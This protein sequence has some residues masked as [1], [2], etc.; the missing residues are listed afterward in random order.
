MVLV[1]LFSL[2][3]GTY[4][5]RQLLRLRDASNRIAQE[6]PGVRIPQRGN[7]E[8][9]QAI[10]AFNLMSSRLAITYADLNDALGAAQR[11][12][13]RIRSSEAQKAALLDAALDAIVTIDID[14]RVV[15][16][17]ASAEQIFGH[18]REEARGQRLEQLMIPERYRAA[19][20]R[21]MERFRAEGVGPALGQRLEMSA[22]HKAGREFPI[23]IAITEIEADETVYFT[24]FMRDIS[25][26][27]RT[28][29][30]LRLAAQAF[31]AQEAIC[32]TDAESRILRVNRAFTAITGYAA[33]EAVG[34]TPRLLKSGRQSRRF[35]QE[36]WERLLRDGHW[37]GEIENRR[38]DGEIFPEW[39]SISA[40]RDQHGKTTNYVAHFIDISERK[41]SEAALIEARA[42]AEQASEAKSRF[43]ATMSHEIRTPLNAIL[44]MNELLLDSGLDPEQAAHARVA[45]EAGRALL[46]VV[47]SILDFSK[48][49]AGRMETRPEPCALEPLLEG[50]LGLFAA[51]AFAKGVELVLT[52]DPQLPQ[53]LDLDPGQ[54]RQILLNLL[55]NALKF[56]EHGA[57]ELRAE[58]LGGGPD[59]RLLIEVVD[60]GIG[61]ARE[62]LPE[63]FNEFVQVDDS[64]QRRYGGT[65]LG[66][67]ICRGLARIMGGE[68]GC[69]SEP[70][71][72][73]HFW[74]RLPL[75]PRLPADDR[76]QRLAQLAAGWRVRVWGASAPLA[77]GLVRQLRLLGVEAAV[78]VDGEASWLEAA[79]AVP[80][81]LQLLPASGHEAPAHEIPLYRDPVDA[82]AAGA[83]PGAATL[84]LMPRALCRLLATAL[85]A[86][87]AFADETLS[88]APGAAV[89]A[90]SPTSAAAPILLVEDSEA[91]RQVALAILVRAGYRVD[92][93]TD[94]HQALAALRARSYALVLMDVSM[95]GMDGLEATRAIRAL[96]NERARVPIVAMTA[97]AFSEDRERC[98][99][100]GMDDYLSKPVVRAELFAALAR[101][102]GD[103]R[104][105]PAPEAAD[106]V[107]LDAT[108]L[109]ELAEDVGEA[110]LTSMLQ[111]FQVETRRRVARIEQAWEAGEIAQ[112]EHE[113][114]TLKGAS[115]TFGARVLQAL[116]LDCEQAAR[117]QDHDR[118][119]PLIARLRECAE[120]ALGALAQRLAG[121]EDGRRDPARD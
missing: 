54:L 39:L 56:T 105:R 97:G 62:R 7:D 12:A 11:L 38:K 109:D 35:Y 118:L 108:V 30:E 69:A 52:L 21:G 95:P 106:S 46:S 50:V 120:Q 29:E 37:E 57:I 68:I 119:A 17:N 2:L 98:L 48:I 114:H 23:E 64:R 9:G 18:S 83:A 102:L 20:R 61:I 77:A 8:I 89:I 84:P 51:R 31:E 115:G 33:H 59:Q 73:S 43:L 67:A 60:T 25:E 92:T 87:E 70:G 22:M 117:A 3:L 103:G 36:M 65:G 63:L 10:R 94:G 78:E 110:F 53:Q 14:G 116:A 44:N 85:G 90:S 5:S 4:L 6:G 101:W 100:A 26:R 19:H 15:D 55:G 42:R 32:V 28:E 1:A 82:T 58:V 49:E 16:F 34:Q 72:G 75:C 99:D 45:G 107:V 93:A 112:L 79:V 104:I 121:D 80:A 86:P 96:P 113:A 13:E 111:T 74:V 71:A 91:N 24:A 76:R 66:L 40:V 27:R 88:S 81:R 41:R 47:D